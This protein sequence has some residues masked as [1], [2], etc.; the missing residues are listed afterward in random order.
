MAAKEYET[1]PRLTLDGVIGYSGRIPNSILAHPNGEHLIYALGAC[2]VIQKISDR[3]SSDFLYGHNDKISYLAV[4]ASGRYIASG[5]M[6]HPGFQADVCIFDF[7][8]RRMI[9]RML[10]H[11]V[12][13]QALAFSSDERY[14]AS[15][16]GIDDKAVV[17]W[18]V[19]T[20]RPLCGA[21]AHH[22]ESKTVVF[23]NNSSDKL[24]TA[25]IGSLRVWTIDGKDRKM[26]AEDVNVGNTRRCITSVVVEA[27][28]RYA[29]CG[30]TTG[31]VMCVLLERDALAYKMSGPQQMLSGGITSMVLDPSGDVLVGSGSGEVALL[32]KINLTI[33]KTVT[34]QGS[35]TGICTVPHGFLVGTMSSNVYL[36]EGGNFRAE[37][38]LTCHSD[39]I[40]DVVFPEGL[41]ALFATC[42]GPDIRVWNAASSAELL[43][44]EIAGLTCNCI[45]F[46]KDGSMIVSGWD[47]GKLRAFGPQSGKLIFAV[48]DAHKKEGL[49]S[50]NGVTG[51]TAVCTD[52]SSERIISGGA[53]GLV[54]VWQV[55][56][57][58]C[59]LEA[60]LSEHKGI[61]NAI[62][63][64]RDNTQCVSASDDGSCIVWDLVRHVRRDVIYSQTRFRAVAYYVDESQLLTTGTNKNITWW[65][66]VD[67]GAIREVPGSKTAEVNSLSLS[68]DGRFFVS[69]GADRIVKVWG[70]DEG[71]CAAVGLAHSC[72]ITK[73]RVSPDG[74]KIVSVGDEGAIMIWSVCDL[75]FKTL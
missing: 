1:T 3:S 23:Y 63:I 49:K 38:R 21:P 67:C 70:Y 34:V 15:I 22:T 52:N 65:D 17:V 45:Q 47:D 2:I 12:K 25:G 59:T 68:T 39:T 48:N 11:K 16:G 31:Y 7:E 57:T 36:V 64:T 19:A 43:R 29:Y 14:L 62:A 56:E 73:V 13:V 44:I 8:Q 71:S 5:Q 60:S 61:V 51:V 37:L 30:T 40:N 33:L 26:T 35:V 54:R 74:K 10:L 27:T 55:R 46:S 58:H 9:H 6:A 20:G 32:S 69:G 50:A 66:S 18:D 28:D 42:C 53:D 4:S 41:S 75:E 24:I 72:N